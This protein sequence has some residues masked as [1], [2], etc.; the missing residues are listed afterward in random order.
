MKPRI[1]DLDYLIRLHEELS[2]SPCNLMRANSVHRREWT[3]G[4]ISGL[5]SLAREIKTRSKNVT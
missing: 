2:F 3:L 5:N 4:V 1:A